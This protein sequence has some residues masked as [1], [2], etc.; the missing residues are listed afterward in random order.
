MSSY[1]PLAFL[2]RIAD[3]HRPW[4]LSDTGGTYGHAPD[5]GNTYCSATDARRSDCE[6]C[7]ILDELPPGVLLR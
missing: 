7:Q 1:A 3:V 6:T 4:H 5:G 2:A